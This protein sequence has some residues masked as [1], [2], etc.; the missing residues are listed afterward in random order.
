MRLI[1]PSSRQILSV[2]A[3]GLGLAAVGCGSQ[4]G[5]GDKITPTP[6]GQ[7]I[8]FGMIAAQTVGT[9]LTL[10]ATATSGLTV[11]FASTTTNICTVSGTTATFVAAGTCTISASQGG[12]ST[13]TAATPVSNSITVNAALIAQT[14]AFANPGAQTVGTPLALSATASSGLMVSFASTT[15]SI[16]TVSN[17]T[18]SFIAA[19]SCTITAS[20]AGNSTYAAATPVSDSFTVTAALI[21]QTITFANPGAQTVGVPLM[22]SAAASS[23]L[24]VSF[25]STT[26]NI[27]TVSGKSAT[28]VAAGSC[29]IAASQVGNSTYAAATPVSD[30][31][32]VNAA[33]I[34]QTITFANPGIQ[35][36]GTPLTL[37]AAASSGLMVSFAS[38][39]TS[40]CTV[41]NA[42]A[43]FIAA[44]SCTITASQ[45]GNSTYAA[46]T[47]V[48]QS[49]AV[50]ASPPNPAPTI[51]SLSPSFVEEGSTTQ[52]ITLTGTHFLTT[53]TATYGGTAHAIT[54]VNSATIHLALTAADQAAAGIK[55][56]ILTNSAPGGGTA[57]ITLQVLSQ[58]DAMLARSQF[59][60]GDQA[61]LQRLIEKG[62]NGLPV[63]IAAIGGSITAGTG[64]TDTPY[65]YVNLVQT[66]WNK[67]FPT[68][69]STLV[70]AGVGATD[71]DY[72]ALRVQRDVLS[73]NPDL[74]IVEFAVNDTGPGVDA[75]GD[76]YEGLVRQLMDGPGQ[77]A[78]ILL[79]MMTYALP[80]QEQYQT[81]QPW[82][83]AIGTNYDLP[84][85]SYF[86]AI[87]PELTNGNITLAEIS[88]DGTHPT[89]LGHAYAAQF[90]EQNL[91]IA[92]DNFPAGTAL[93]S[94]PATQS[95][96]HSS[97][98]E[99]TSL[100]D[101]AT[102]NPSSNVGWVAEPANVPFSLGYISAGLQS[103]TPGS[104]LDFEVTGREILLGYWVFDGPMGQASV[105]VD[106]V[107]YPDVLDGWFNQTWGGERGMTRVANSLASGT[108]QVH[109][110]LLSTYDSGSTGNDFRLVCVGTGGTQ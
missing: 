15:N 97:E 35:S 33:L 40:I 87:S 4:S 67:T 95:P 1:T 80:I 74:V 48:S 61:R 68:S 36:V 66:W 7:T 3:V 5:A 32:T 84:M 19:G 78:V 77:P 82:Q 16:C 108:H 64:A 30:S 93:E 51:A 107:A 103:S 85:V 106:G 60:A 90:L 57:S 53:T 56:I 104:T 43:S 75:L 101:G 73:Q 46:A 31:F 88:G 100:V 81:S 50:S 25:A 52:T 42:T 27:C 37:S 58:I 94:I 28:F 96:L 34:A 109:V 6:E 22:L 83:S 20:Q 9:P 23:G 92:I 10:S 54:Y 91:Q 105:T 2:F 17:A 70:N 24:A 8:A 13:Y 44:G 55:T 11:S 41:S 18:A 65:R 39:T 98:F 47:P 29:T 45:A 99:F 12:N 69:H 63:T 21:A 14:I 110:D 62:R 26:A 76:T 86:D 49:F 72:G 89:D 38:T 102:L 79:F 71:S 59:A